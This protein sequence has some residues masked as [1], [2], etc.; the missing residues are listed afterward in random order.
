MTQN[1]LILR[2]LRWAIFLF[3]ALEVS[4]RVEHR[5]T[6]ATGC[7]LSPFFAQQIADMKKVTDDYRAK[8]PDEMKQVGHQML[9]ARWTV[10]GITAVILAGL[11]VWLRKGS[12]GMPNNSLQA[13]TAAPAN[14]D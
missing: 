2:F 11:I 14:Y 4:S 5:L 9:V 3:I 12:Q 7:Q 13:T 10:H 1:Q 8:H 6:V